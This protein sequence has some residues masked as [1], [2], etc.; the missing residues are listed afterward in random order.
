MALLKKKAADEFV[1]PSLS[2]DP[3]YAAVLQR[4]AELNA[5]MSKLISERR[6]LD[7]KIEEQPKS[8]YSAGVSR[9]LGEDEG[10]APHLR[11]RR[12]EVLGEIT[13]VETA[14]VVIRK[15]L[16]EARNNASRSVCDS[17]RGEYQ[18]RLGVLCDAARALEVARQDH[19]ALLDQLDAEDIRKDYLRPVIPHFMGDRREGRAF[20]FLKEVKEAGY[21]V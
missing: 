11:K 2:D 20:Y 12:A 5:L 1:V 16:E 19:D 7:K 9:L 21:N 8:P 18:R 13:D 14:L 3:A 17:V 4:Q 15:R 6:D 10:A